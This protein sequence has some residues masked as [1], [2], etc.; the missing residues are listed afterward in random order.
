MLGFRGCRLGIVHPA[1]TR[2]QA[3]A[4][5]EAAA[6]VA[7]EEAGK[8]EDDRSP[9]P[10]VKIMIPLVGFQEE[11]R[12]QIRVV[13]QAAK[14][15]FEEHPELPKVEFEVGTMIELPRAALAA[16]SLAAP[17][18]ASF[19]SVGSNDLTQTCLGFS[20]DDAE[21][22]FLPFYLREGILPSDPFA[23]VDE[24]GV[25]ELVKLALERGRSANKDLEVGVCGEHGGDPKSIAFFDACRL[26]YVSCSPLRVPLAR[27][28]AA[29]A[30]I[31]R[32]RKGGDHCQD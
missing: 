29:Q 25:G 1:I 30:A 27:L 6:L 32:R 12:A 16:A 21:A 4:I 9:P 7:A 18:L 17:G 10:K 8:P 31:Q 5:L 15:V 23:T 24:A 3:Q 28:A 14:D 26:S 11:L 19:F 20:R 13:E 2:M 22:R